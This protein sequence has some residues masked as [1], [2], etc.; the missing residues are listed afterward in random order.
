MANENNYPGAT[1]TLIGWTAS[2]ARPPAYD[3][4]GSRGILEISVPLNEGYTP[5]DGGEFVKTSTTWYQYTASGEY[6]EALRNIPK[7]SKVKIEG[8]KQEVR[9]YKDRE[10]N[11]KLG[12]G[13]RF[14]TITVLESA[15]SDA[16]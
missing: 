1:L 15:D 5:K 12:I 10:G 6:A 3:K 8:A 13:L 11:E 16:F 4:D 7:G 9:S 2:D 14:G